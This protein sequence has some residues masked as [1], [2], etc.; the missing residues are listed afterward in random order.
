LLSSRDQFSGA[1]KGTLVVYS[2]DLTQGLIEYNQW[3]HIS[4]EVNV[5]NIV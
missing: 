2:T 3:C 5:Y 4:V 1:D